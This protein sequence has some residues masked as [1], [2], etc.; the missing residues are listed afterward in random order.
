MYGRGDS[1][2]FSGD[3]SQSFLDLL[4][5]SSDSHGATIYDVNLDSTETWP[6]PP[7]S[8][9]PDS[10]TFM[11]PVADYGI[12]DNGFWVQDRQA[13]SFWPTSGLPDT[14]AELP[15]CP[16]EN[17]FYP[18]PNLAFVGQTTSQLPDSNS[19]NVF[20]FPT[21]VVSKS[22]SQIPSRTAPPITS[23]IH[24]FEDQF[25][26]LETPPA[27]PKQDAIDEWQFQ[28]QPFPQR[29]ARL[30]GV[31]TISS[32]SEPELDEMDIAQDDLNVF[33]DEEAPNPAA[34]SGPKM[35]GRVFLNEPAEGD[36]LDVFHERTVSGPASTSHVSAAD[37][38]DHLRLKKAWQESKGSQ[39]LQPLLKE[40]LRLK[41]LKKRLDSGQGELDIEVTEPP[42]YQVSES[43]QCFWDL[44]SADPLSCYR[45][46]GDCLKGPF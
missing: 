29:R 34:T 7:A 42:C 28:Q 26:S 32:S 38:R 1:T 22:P 17:I 43:L 23:T 12:D 31:S 27:T 18:S 6:F 44:C 35:T 21:I 30:G 20:R 45:C 2:P 41:I 16:P 14:P 36:D 19:Q 13:Q 9:T 37:W 24:S 15:D 25:I 8:L 11:V 46:N 33:P 10:P 40:E 5:F 3:S 4:C 39:S